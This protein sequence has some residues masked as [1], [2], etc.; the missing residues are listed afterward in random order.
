MTPEQLV[1]AL[2]TH[3]ALEFEDTMAVIDEHFDYTPTA[4][5]NGE[6]A[7]EPGQNAGSCKILAF[8]QFMGLSEEEALRGFGRFYRDVQ[9]TP[10]GDDHGNIRNFIRY[11]WSGVSFDSAPLQ[12][13]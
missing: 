4:F 10:D 3:Q 2:K 5:K 6:Q 9:N 11:G 1:D 12:R 7:N 13:R 8:G